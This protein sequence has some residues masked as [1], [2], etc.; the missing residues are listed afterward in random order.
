[1]K[2][3]LSESMTRT[4]RADAITGSAAG[5]C[6]SDSDLGLPL[7]CGGLHSHP[8]PQPERPE[9]RRVNLKLALWADSDSKGRK[10]SADFV[11]FPARFTAF[12]LR[13]FIHF[14]KPLCRPLRIIARAKS[15]GTLS[16]HSARSFGGATDALSSRGRSAQWDLLRRAM[17][18]WHRLGRWR[19]PSRPSLEPPQRKAGKPRVPT[20]R[21][22]TVL[23]AHL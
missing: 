4:A 22:L 21:S 20:D 12:V 19:S 6:D 11:G 7:S 5:H 23:T 9:R 14:P 1:M 10:R 15:I 3:R 18:S 2:G 8:P 13:A 17:L 16:C